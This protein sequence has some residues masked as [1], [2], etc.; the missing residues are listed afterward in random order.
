MRRRFPNR[1][2]GLLLWAIVLLLAPCAHAQIP[3]LTGIVRDPL[4]NPVADVDLDFIDPVT[5]V[6]LLTPGDNTD[7]TGFYNVCVLPR[8][9]DVT[10]AP[11]PGSHLLGRRFPNFDMNAGRVLDLTLEFGAALFGS[12]TDTAGQPVGDVDLD[13]DRLTGGRLFTPGD[14]TD[15]VTGSYWIVVPPGAY[16]VRFDPPPGSRLR[17]LQLDT[18]TVTG[19]QNLDVSLSAGLLLTGR[20]RDAGGSDLADIDVELRE[21][22]TGEKI[23]MSNN[24]TDPSGRYSVAV[25]PGTFNFRFVPP[26]GSRLLGVLIDSFM[27][28]GDLNR[29]Q[30]LLPGALVTAGVHDSA[31]NPIGDADI[32]FKQE[33]SGQKLFTP[34][35]NTDSAGIV[36]SAVPPDLYTVQVDP[37]IGS[38]FDQFVQHNVTISGDTLLEIQLAEVARVSFGGRVVDGSGVGVAGAHIGLLVQATG[39]SVFVRNDLTD[40]LGY[41]AIA[42]PQGLFEVLFAPPVGSRLVGQKRSQVAFSTDTT[43]ALV[44]LE[45][46]VIVDV[47]VFD[48]QGLPA[49]GADLDFITESG[50]VEIYTPYDNVNALGTARVAV[51]PGTYTLRIEAPA[52]G[53]LVGTDLPGLN[54]QSDT[55]VTLILASTGGTLPELPFVLRQNFPN[56]FNGETRIRFVMLEP[57]FVSIKLY[58]ILGQ[59]VKWLASGDRSMGLHEVTWDGADDFGRAVASGIYFYRLETPQASQTRK[60]VLLR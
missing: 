26:R 4:G 45:A 44:V 54:L 15:L 22:A 50:G 19:D 10:F 28:E 8:T 9:Y 46:G 3:C 55:A 58:N 42:V 35:D 51:A 47:N 18:V 11:A 53:S 23:F 16:R 39:K 29:E 32:D 5:G 41:F 31:G 14:N 48:E 17:G 40:S 60:L 27:I 24:T 13:V 12:V 21:F 36:H 59:P 25:P 37:P 56:P 7:V 1:T 2:G 38:V 43:W 57:S 20:V 33:S 30:T 6:K 34:N 49:A 52:G